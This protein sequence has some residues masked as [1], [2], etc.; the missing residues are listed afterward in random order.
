M[1]TNLVG[2]EKQERKRVHV[3][4]RFIVV[5]AVFLYTHSPFPLRI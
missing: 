5:F 1:I 2:G 4:L 3:M